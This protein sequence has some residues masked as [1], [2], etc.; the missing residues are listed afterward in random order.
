MYPDLCQVRTLSDQTPRPFPPS[1]LG[2]SGTLKKTLNNL[3][4]KPSQSEYSLEVLRVFEVEVETWEGYLL[5]EHSSREGV[6]VGSV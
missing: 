4:P 3:L 5:E 2:V 1:T 6:A